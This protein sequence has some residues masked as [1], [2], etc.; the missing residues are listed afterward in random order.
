MTSII[1]V[2]EIQDAGGNT[3]L[4]SNGTGTFTSNLPSA[5]N[6]PNFEVQQTTGQNI[7]NTSFTKLTWNIE[8]WDTDSAFASDKFTVPS[9]QAGKYYF[10]ATTELTAIPDST[11]AQ[12][13]VYKNGSATGSGTSRWYGAGGGVGVRVRVNVILNLSVSDYIE[14]YIYHNKGSSQSASTS[15]TFFRGYKLIE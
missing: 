3:I 14:I 2:N 10:Q 8:N 13:M 7:N 1:K 12:L 4:S 15:E 5:D 11:F 9:G 6:T